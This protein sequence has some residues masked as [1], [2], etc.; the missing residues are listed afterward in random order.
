MGVLPAPVSSGCLQIEIWR[1]IGGKAG[2]D[3]QARLLADALD[4]PVKD[5]PLAF[6]PAYDQ[7][8]P[9]FRASFAHL[10][11][12][13]AESLAPPWPRLVIA[14]GRR[15][16]M[17]ALE[18]KKR[19]QG[20]SKTLLLGRPR[21][22]RDFDLIVAPS[23]FLTP[24]AANICR[25]PW[26]LMQP[27]HSA[28]EAQSEAWAGRFENLERP[29][30]TVLVGGATVPYA[31]GARAGVD[32]VERA[33]AATGHTG[34]LY[35]CTSRRSGRAL[36]EA[37]RHMVSARPDNE[38]LFDWSAA[39]GDNPY[40]ALLGLADRHIVTGDSLS[41]MLEVAQLGAPLALYIPPLGMRPRS[42]LARGSRPFM[43][44]WNQGAQRFEPRRVTN[45]LFQSGL[46]NYARDLGAIHRQLL[47]SGRATLLGEGFASQAEP[48]DLQLDEVAARV[49]ALLSGAGS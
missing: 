11:P 40:L 23:H 32:L 33:R 4:H 15:P 36:R 29:L 19:S 13:V 39:N 49:N 26:P 41:M 8:K 2:D 12:G 38:R 16:A 47:A 30:T 25:V 42:L 21:H 7:G 46:I 37:I 28:I 35:F 48:L 44:A 17:V 22:R 9:W 31:L 3:S 24:R 27:N 34:T 20:A 5:K 6:K 43:Y 10:A 18:I 14:V 1:L 45:V